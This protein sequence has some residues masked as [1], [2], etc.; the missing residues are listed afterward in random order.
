MKNMFRR[1]TF[2]E[3]T[4]R[5]LTYAI[6]IAFAIYTLW[7]LIQE[8]S[9][10]G[11]VCYALILIVFLGIASWAEYVKLIYQKMLKALLMDTDPVKAKQYYQILKKKDILKSY[12]NSLNIF[13]TLYYQDTNA[14]DACIQLLDDN[15]KFFRSSLDFLLIRNYTYFYAYYKSGNRTKA[16]QYYPEVI[17]L[18]GTKI[19]GAKLHP[20]YSWEFIDAMYLSVTKDYKKSEQM[21]ARVN[22]INMNHRELSQYYVEYGKACMINGNKQHAATLFTKALE[23]G[24]RLASGIEA[25]QLLQK[26]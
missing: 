16:K 25:K 7:Q 20:L 19:K 8:P 9:I 15:E 26:L 3:Q 22:P 18:R 11:K 24:S 12:T 17:K 6:F 21:F 23:V 4:R 2:R 5:I 1:F 10:A 13:D 14:Y